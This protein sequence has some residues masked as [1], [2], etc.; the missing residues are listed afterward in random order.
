MIGTIS[1]IVNLDG[2]AVKV[3]LVERMLAYGPEGQAQTSIVQIDQVVIGASDLRK[4]SSFINKCT[5]ISSS[6]LGIAWTGRLDNR[7]EIISALGASGKT[8]SNMLDAEIV[9]YTYKVWGEN[10]VKK[11]IGEFAFSIWDREIK[12]VIC[13]V[14]HYSI[15]PLFYHFDGKTLTFGSRIVQVYQNRDI[16]YGI[17]ENILDEHFNPWCVLN[18]ATDN[19]F[20]TGYKGV[21]R[22]PHGCLLLADEKGLF[23]KKYWDINPKKEIV[24][25]KESDYY[26][27]FEE[28]FRAAVSCRLETSCQ[29]IGFQ[30]TGG[31][32]SSSVVMMAHDIFKKN[33][34]ERDLTTFT[35]NFDELSCNERPYANIIIEACQAKGVFLTGDWLFGEWNLPLGTHQPYDFRRIEQNNISLFHEAVFQ[36]AHEREIDVILSGHAADFYLEGNELILDSLLRRFSLQRFSKEFKTAL[37]GHPLPKKLRVFWDFCLTPLLP[38]NWSLPIFYKRVYSIPDENSLP[39]FFTEKFRKKMRDKKFNYASIP[40]MKSW[41]QQD[42]YVSL[43]PPVYYE[44]S[45]NLPIQIRYPYLDKRL[46]E[47]GLAVPPEIKFSFTDGTTF[48]RRSKLLQRRGLSK[49]LPDS[50]RQRDIKTTYDDVPVEFF[51]LYGNSIKA[52]FDRANGPILY[53]NGYLNPSKFE[54]ALEVLLSSPQRCLSMEETSDVWIRL[55]IRA[56]IWL[57]TFLSADTQANLI[58]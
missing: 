36:A 7:K 31:L 57:R 58:S 3:G 30:L 9:L 10:C 5:A 19:D 23:I 20:I 40:K 25:S 15:C 49:I 32:D 56:E 24:Y 18:E 42:D 53:E 6:G 45:S 8:H 37:A 4:S 47:F 2:K 35:V 44:E 39:D 13:A 55:V 26:E 27:H 51:K 38:R 22:L 11:L 46:I 28:L 54:E 1:G 52:L 21:K 34:T 48:Y 50:I 16:Q 29:S 17:D 33:Q 14:D 43:F 41:G 12:R